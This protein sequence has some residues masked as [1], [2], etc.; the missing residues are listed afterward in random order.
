MV[1]SVDIISAYL[2]AFISVTGTICS[3]YNVIFSDKSEDCERKEKEETFYLNFP[4]KQ[5]CQ[6]M[7]STGNKAKHHIFRSQTYQLFV[8]VRCYM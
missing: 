1:S 7:L 3:F 6:M 4:S 8:K 5:S 2:T